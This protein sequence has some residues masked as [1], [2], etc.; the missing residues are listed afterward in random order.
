QSFVYKPK[1]EDKGG[2]KKALLLA[3]EKKFMRKNIA[4][5]TGGEATEVG[6]ALKSAAVVYKHLSKEKYN[7]YKIL[8]DGTDWW[9]LENETRIAKIDKNDFS[10]SLNGK[11]IRFDAVFIIIH[12]TP[13]EDGKLQGYFDL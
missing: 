6:I 5:I 13:A 10:L 7:V 9:F 8:I 2:I 4:V 11:K 12:G 1:C 3:I